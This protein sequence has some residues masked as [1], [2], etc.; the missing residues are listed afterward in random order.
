MFLAYENKTLLLNQGVNQV[1]CG[2]VKPPRDEVC[3]F[4][5]SL[6]GPC[7][8]ENGYGYKNRTPCVIVKL[9]RVSEN[10]LVNDIA[11]VK[12]PVKACHIKC[13]L[14]KYHSDIWEFRHFAS[15]IDFGSKAIC[16]QRR[17]AS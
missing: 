1:D 11:R 12:D 7:S 17:F 4:N 3:A 8:R 5:T 10:Q 15:C 16:I 9:N 13:S 2:D 14:F 6:L